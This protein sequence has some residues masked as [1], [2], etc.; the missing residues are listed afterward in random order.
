MSRRVLFHFAVVGWDP[1]VDDVEPGFQDFVRHL[2]FSAYN[3]ENKGVVLDLD[4]FFDLES[5][6]FLAVLVLSLR[7]VFLRLRSP[8]GEQI[9]F[10]L[11]IFR[12]AR[13]VSD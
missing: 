10:S 11:I 6:F 8:L 2:G 12:V 7:V 3:F 4:Y 5:V 9:W 13:L 1:G